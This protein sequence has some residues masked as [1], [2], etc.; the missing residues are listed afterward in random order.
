M[1]TARVIVTEIEY[2]T[3]DVSV[4]HLRDEG[5]YLPDEL[6]LEVDMENSEDAEEEIAD[7]ISDVTG[8]CVISFE[9]KAYAMS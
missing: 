3:D 2:D 5:A 9:Y 7:A 1:K 4:E 8:F 6:V